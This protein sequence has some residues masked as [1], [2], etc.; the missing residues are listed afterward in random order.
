MQAILP[1]LVEVKLKESDQGSM[2][3]RV[4]ETLE[5]IG[6]FAADTPDVLNQVAHLITLEGKQYIAHF[7]FL[8]LVFHG[9]D[10]RLK[11]SDIARQNKA[12]EMLVNWGFIEV[13]DPTQMEGVSPQTPAGVKVVR[14]QDKGNWKLT[15]KFRRQRIAPREQQAEA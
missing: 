11:D 6:T 10:N 5:R 7:K 2:A 13:V 3:N 15:P 9:T 14:H 4:R 8:Y 12:I 1:Y